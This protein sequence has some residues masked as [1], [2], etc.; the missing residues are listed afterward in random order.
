MDQRSILI[1]NLVNGVDR[2]K[3]SAVSPA[4]HQQ[5][6]F[7]HAIRLNVPLHVASALQGRWIICGSDDRSVRIFDQRTET[8]IN[9]LRHGDGKHLLFL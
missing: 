4:L 3:I 1:S 5:Q 6:S 7:K 8:I 9:S 2:Y